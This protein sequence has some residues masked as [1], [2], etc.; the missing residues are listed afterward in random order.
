MALSTI[1]TA[2]IANDAI[3]PDKIINDG[4]LGVRNLIINGAMQVAQRS[5]SVSSQT[6]SGYKTTDR[7]RTNSSGGTYNQSRQTVPLG[8]SVVGD[9]KYFLRHE[10]TTGDNFTGI[11]QRIEDVQSVAEGTVTLSFYAKGTNPNAGSIAIGTNQYF[12]TGGSPSTN[13]EVQDAATFTVT[14]SWQRFNFQLTVAS[15][16]GKTLGTNGDSYFQ[17]QFTQAG[18]DAS[19]DAWTLDIT[20]VQL[21]LGDTATPFEH[22]SFGNELTRC[23]RYYQK[24]WYRSNNIFTDFTGTQYATQSLVNPVRTNGTVTNS[25]STGANITVSSMTIVNENTLQIICSSSG[26]HNNWV[27]GDIFVDAEL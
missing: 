14:S 23:Q 12:G 19:T 21:E 15:I 5:T 11:Q 26:T 8:D 25:V 20:G 1:K 22:R 16:S 13:V 4:N 18:G 24:L 3:T 2:S 7:W 17:I 27:T 6:G 9:F 10:V